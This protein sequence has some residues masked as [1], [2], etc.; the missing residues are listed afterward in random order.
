MKIVLHIGAWKTGSSAIQMFLRKN[1]RRLKPHGVIVPPMAK[2]AKGHQKVF[3]CL[4]H[5]DEDAFR[6][7]QEQLQGLAEEH[8]EGVAV[9]SSEHYWPMRPDRIAIV[10]ERL[11]RVTDDVEVLLYVRAQD[12]MWA[13]L[14]AQEAKFFRVTTKTAKWGNYDYMGGDITDRAIYYDA[15]L[16]NFRDAFGADRVHARSYT[17]DAFVGGDVIRDFLAFVGLASTDNLVFDSFDRN[18]SLGWKGVSFSIWFAETLHARLTETNEEPR[19][20]I[21]KAFALTYSEVKKRFRDQDWVGRA[22][23]IFDEAERREI[24]EHYAE[25]NRALFDRYFGGAN[26]FG[27]VKSSAA[28]PLDAARIPEKQWRYA[29]GR[30]Y[31]NFKRQ[32]LNVAAIESDLVPRRVDRAILDAI[33][34]SPLGWFD[35]KTKAE[36][37]KE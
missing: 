33:E 2:Q 3:S 13:S 23:E 12:D 1:L 17:R 26:V 16:A 11:R 24:R 27:E 9:I 22:A 7:F 31:V 28:T 21:R 29:T 36:L 30:L 37:L 32:G 6:P 18:P 25:D 15:C 8:P 4:V 34:N 10:A 19:I 5:G 35:R 14:Y 20:P